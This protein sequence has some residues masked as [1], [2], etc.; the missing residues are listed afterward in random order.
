MSSRTPDGGYMPTF[1]SNYMLDGFDFN[2]EYGEGPLMNR[3]MPTT[4]RT[5]GMAAPPRSENGM[6]KLPDGIVTNPRAAAVDDSELFAGGDGTDVGDLSEMVREASHISDLSWLELAEQDPDRLPKQHNDKVLQGLVDAWGVNKRTDGV[7]IVPN[8]VVPPPPRSQVALLPGDDTL[9]QVVA[10]AMR[11]SAFGVPFDNILAEVAAHLGPDAL[12]RVGTDSRL[13]KFARAVR[14]IKAEHGISGTVYLRDSAF[15]GLLTGKWDREIKKRCASAHYWLTRP[16]SK[17]AA[18]Q[19]YL[20]KRVV[21]EIPWDEALSHYRPTLESSGKRL[22]SGDPKTVLIAALRAEADRTEKSSHHTYHLTPAQRVSS[23][24]AWK[25]FAS[26]PVPQREILQ[27]D[28]VRVTLEQAR[29]RFASWV[30]NGLL[31]EETVRS[32]LARNAPEEAL[33][34]GATHIASTHKSSKYKG[35][36]IGA[37]TPER[38]TRNAD[39]AS[40]ESER[41]VR[42]TEERAEKVSRDKVASVFRAWVKSGSLTQSQSDQILSRASGDEAVRLGQHVINLAKKTEY[43]GQG[44]GRSVHTGGP[45]KKLAS[46]H[47]PKVAQVLRYA[48]AQ[49]NEGAAGNDLDVLLNSRF[50]QE[51][52]K[53]ASEQLVQIRRKHEGLAGHVYIAADAYASPTGTTGCDKG[54]LIHRANQ[55]KSVLQME[56][57]GSCAHNTEGHCQKYNKT[58]VT[59]APVSNPE[60]YQRETIRLANA[61]D[62]ERT[63]AMFNAYDPGE[64]DLQNDSLD[65]F[66]YDNLPDNKTLHGILFEGMTI[67][68]E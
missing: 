31:T 67:P 22:A 23:E 17:L 56:R 48:S 19:N 29:Q 9:R 11:K 25:V 46:A 50:S 27:K 64:F 10:S 16:G 52:L 15:P 58:L 45:T 12:A 42:A 55:V 38:R 3:K 4:S 39:W 24:Q 7:E 68:E 35:H 59:A 33:R 18:Y 6:A 41:L 5:T 13:Q 21:T 20:G 54:A 34:V 37:K 66:D 14:S 47:D 2:E 32:L 61:D 65:T 30:Q 36:G 1:A 49:M 44:R 43:K 53:G 8:V 26:A 60:K 28:S 57:C 62:S 51:Y 40:E 63:A